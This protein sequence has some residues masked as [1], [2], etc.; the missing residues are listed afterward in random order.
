M[1]GS[2]K[3]LKKLF[4]SYEHISEDRHH[5]DDSK[6]RTQI[7]L[8]LKELFPGEHITEKMMNVA[9]LLVYPTKANKDN[10]PFSQGLG[11]G[12]IAIY[13]ST[14]D[15]NT[16]GKINTFFNDALVRKFWPKLIACSDREFYFKKEVTAASSCRKTLC[17]ISYEMKNLYKLQLPQ[18]W[19]QE[20]PPIKAQKTKKNISSGRK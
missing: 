2:R 15:S 13:K 19:V 17:H 12:G 4:E 7:A 6:W 20:F 5:W 16:K 3:A 10:C 1:R 14:F 18:F 9:V 8:F 11:N